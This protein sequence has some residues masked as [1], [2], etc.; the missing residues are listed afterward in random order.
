MKAARYVSVH[1]A[2]FRLPK[3]NEQPGTRVHCRH[4]SLATLFSCFLV[5][6]TLFDLL[7]RRY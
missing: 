6:E 1:F 4:Q 3:S 5:N 7:V 2:C